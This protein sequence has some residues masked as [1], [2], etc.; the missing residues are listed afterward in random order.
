[1]NFAKKITVLE[2]YIIEILNVTR[3][4]V[5]DLCLLFIKEMYLTFKIR[6]CVLYIIKPLKYMYF[7]L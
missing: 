7:V 1:M 5:L 2:I 3:I 6:N 4:Q